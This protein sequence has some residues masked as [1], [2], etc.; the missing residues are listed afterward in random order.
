M[1]KINI[2]ISLKTKN[3]R[4]P[5]VQHFPNKFDDCGKGFILLDGLTDKLGICIM[6]IIQNN[7]DPKE[8][9]L[10]QIYE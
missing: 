4:V 5:S 9:R 3:F 10:K 2:D 7:R 6:A 1:F 8:M